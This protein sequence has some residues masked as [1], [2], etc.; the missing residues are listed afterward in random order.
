MKLSE[1]SLE[2]LLAM[3]KKRNCTICV[4]YGKVIIRRQSLT[5]QKGEL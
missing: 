2:Y 5:M 1:V 4:R 3:I